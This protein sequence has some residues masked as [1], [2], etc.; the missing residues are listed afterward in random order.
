MNLQKRLG[1]A[2]DI[3]TTTI[4]GSLLDLDKKERLAYSSSLNEQITL[5]HDIISR[6]KCCLEKPDGLEKLHKR[7]ISSINYIL[8]NLLSSSREDREDIVSIAAVGN[9]AMYHFV[10]F[11]N[12]EKLAEPPYQPEHK[13][14]AERAAGTLGIRSGKDCKF[15]FLPNIGGFVGS[16]ALA[17]IMTTGMDIF[18]VPSIAVDIGTNSE[19]MLGS[20]DKI[21]VG[22]AAAGPA[23]EGW[24]ITCGMRAVRGAIESVEEEGGGLKIKV[25]GDAPPMGISGSGL[26]DII[27]ILIKKGLIENSGS[28]K[29]TFVIHEGKKKIYLSQ[30]D[31]RQA[32]LAKAAF[33]AGISLLRKRSKEGVDKFFITGNFGNYINKENARILG[34]I[35]KDI[36][37]DRVEFLKEAALK[38]AEAFIKNENATLDRIKSILKKTEHV[39]LSREDGFRDEFTRALRFN[40]IDG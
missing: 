35:P 39:S 36:D 17:V 40:D 37:L 27:A 11:L 25:I 5:G 2:L 12:P 10:L 29:D 8:E 30:E 13:G 22:S 20:K 24:H 3:G 15:C 16:D 6:I 34:I 38:G 33:S 28:L 26:I 23:F 1:V 31:V 18:E 9:T 14:L 19:V 32:Q 4:R 21:W 7:V